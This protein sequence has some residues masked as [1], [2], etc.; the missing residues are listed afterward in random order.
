MRANHIQS[1]LALCGC[2]RLGQLGADSQTIAIFHGGVI[3]MA[4]P[5]RLATGILV[6]SRIRVGG[7]RVGCV[8]ALLIVEITLGVAACGL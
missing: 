1:C 6:K 2:G 3:H 8:T 7:R 5:G 4:K